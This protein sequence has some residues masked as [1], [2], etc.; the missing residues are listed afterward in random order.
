MRCERDIIK[1]IFKEDRLNLFCE[2]KMQKNS[3]AASGSDRIR[4]RLD[5]VSSINGIEADRR[6]IH[7]DIEIKCFY[8]GS[9][10]LL[11]GNETVLASAGDVVV[12]NPYEFHATI[13]YSEDK[14][15]YHMFMI[16]L[17]YF[18]EG[19]TAE[20]ELMLMLRA[21]QTVLL[22]HY[23]NDAQIF[24][25]MMQLA[26]EYRCKETAYESAMRG[27]FIQLFALLVRRG[28]AQ[29]GDPDK[30]KNILVHYKLIEPAL[31][32]IRDNYACRIDI[33]ELALMCGLSKHYFCHVFKSVIGQSPMAYLND[34]R[35]KVAD[36][37]LGNT[38]KSISAVA[39]TCGFES[40]NYFCRK[41]KIFYGIS[42]GKRRSLK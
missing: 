23:K 42:P 4:V 41:Y 18:S 8:E 13:A 16:P 34:H 2:A 27:I 1:A 3:R 35:I 14:G 20:S 39:E 38:E 31:R 22:R 25:L 28:T 21:G 26:N 37:L 32:H 30:K 5:C 33:G 40:T 36:T 15:K 7:E 19:D 29:T 6:A 9:A 17:D 12:I 24:D 11:V 10:T